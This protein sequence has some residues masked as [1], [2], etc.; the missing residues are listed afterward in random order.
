[1]YCHLQ[2]E[3]KFNESRIEFYSAEITLALEHLH[4]LDIIYRDLKL[5]N[6]LL[7]AKG[8]LTFALNKFLSNMY[9]F[10]FRMNLIFLNSSFRMKCQFG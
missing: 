6:I 9:K 2:Q 5:E 8:K 3:Q 1:M 4:S 10:D 7:D